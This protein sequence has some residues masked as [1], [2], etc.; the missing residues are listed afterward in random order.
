MVRYLFA[1]TLEVSN[2][3][4]CS[5]QWP[6]NVLLKISWKPR[7]P[8]SYWK[9]QTCVLLTTHTLFSYMVWF[10]APTAWCWYLTIYI[11]CTLIC[12]LA[13][14]VRLLIFMQFWLC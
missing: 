7:W 14:C 1:D 11:L 13:H 8:S 2:V 4:H 5:F 12:M 10:S 6:W 9:L 3:C